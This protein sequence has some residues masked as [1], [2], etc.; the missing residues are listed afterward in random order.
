[1]ATALDLQLFS[2]DRIRKERAGLQPDIP[3]HTAYGT[4]LYSA[5]VTRATYD[6]LTE[7]ACQHLVG[8]QSVILDAS[9]SKRTERQR[10]AALAHEVGADCCLLECVAP[11]ASMR[12]RLEQRQRAAASISDGRW[13]IFASFQ[14]AYEP[15]QADELAWHVRLDM[16]QSVEACVQQALAALEE[17]RAERDQHARHSCSD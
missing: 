5:A 11:V 3:Q 13:E 1:V 14:H 7:L 15:V 2:A 4:G 16:T 10:L 6:A 12:Q 17:G 9:F 8:G